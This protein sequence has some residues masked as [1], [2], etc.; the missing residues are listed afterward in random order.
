M[1]EYSVLGLALVGA[2]VAATAAFIGFS[3]I[4]RH[5]KHVLLLGLALR[6]AGSQVYLRFIAFAYGGGD[7][8]LYFFGGLEYAEAINAGNWS[9]VIDPWFEPGWYGTS[10]IIRLTGLILSVIGPTESGLFLVYGLIGYIGIIAFWRAYRE[11][12]PS[13]EG[14][15]YLAWIAVFPSL[16]FWPAAVGKDTIVLCGIGIAT[17]GFARRSV[18]RGWIALAAGLFLVFIVRPQVAAVVVFAMALAQTFGSGLR[19]QFVPLMRLGAMVAMAAAIVVWSSRSMEVELYDPEEVQGYLEEK[20]E[21]TNIGGS[22]ISSEG[23]E[24]GVSRW[25]APINTLFRPFPWEVRGLSAGLAAIEVLVFWGIV[26]WRRRQISI[27][28]RYA[29]HKPLFWLIVFFGLGYSIALGITLT[30]IGMIAR[31]RVHIFPFIFMLFSAVPVA[32]RYPRTQ[33]AGR[34]PIWNRFGRATEPEAA[35]ALRSES[36]A[37]RP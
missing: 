6:V 10:A 18:F 11:S 12:F 31:Q 3:G 25:L 22:A 13:I 32:R 2:L 37:N 1:I 34:H 4:P 27:F 9:A 26:F 19:L 29:R 15:H 28:A 20:S 7:Y 23:G 21:S 33:V 17:L 24:G 16:W 14:S 5:A 36:P 8:N 35:P 30:N